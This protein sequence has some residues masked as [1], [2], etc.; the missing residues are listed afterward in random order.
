MSP[1]SIF[2]SYASRSLEY[3][4]TATMVVARQ[5]QNCRSV[6]G[7]MCQAWCTEAPVWYAPTKINANYKRNV[8]N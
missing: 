1:M 6:A 7:V 5:L 2:Y 4:S 3:M 8:E